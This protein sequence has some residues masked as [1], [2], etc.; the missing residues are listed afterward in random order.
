MGAW[1]R[2][3]RP[4]TL[5]RSALTSLHPAPL[6]L[7]S[8]CLPPQ[9]RYSERTVL[10]AGLAELVH[11]QDVHGDLTVVQRV[12]VVQH[13]EEQVETRQQRVGQAN[14]LGRLLLAVVLEG[15]RTGA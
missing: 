5:A 13:D 9:S 11:A 3:V 12:H 7:S 2:K 14:V 4:P 6:R 15:L 1:F 8:S 10:F